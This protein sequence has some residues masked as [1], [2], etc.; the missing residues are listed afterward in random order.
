MKSQGLKP[1]TQ[2]KRGRRSKPGIGVV[3]FLEPI[4]RDPRVHM[5]HVV[6]ADIAGKPL[7]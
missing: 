3:A 4:I 1:C 2:G 6:K 7:E 5:V